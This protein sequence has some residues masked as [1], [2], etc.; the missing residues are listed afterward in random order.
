MTHATALERC[1]ARLPWGHLPREG[2]FAT[3]A[4]AEWLYGEYFI[5]WRAPAQPRLEYSGSPWF[6]AELTA[7]CAGRTTFEPGFTVTRRVAG[8]AFVETAGISLWVPQPRALRPSNARVGTAV[9]VA[10]PCIREAAIAG[11]FTIVSRAGRLDPAAPHLK[12]YV[13]ATPA[14]A[15][16]LLGGLLEAPSLRTARFEAKVTNDPAHFGR[17]DTL[18]LYV[19]PKH[20]G[21]VAAFLRRFAR[22]TPRALNSGTPPMTFPLA[23]GVAIAESPAHHAESFGSHRCRLVAEG[24]LT[25]RAEG[26]PMLTAVAERFEREGLSWDEPWFG[27]LPRGWLARL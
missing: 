21:R 20:A 25:A 22:A 5:S 1:V 15:V 11:F 14:G 26:R 19:T 2:A 8:G 18:L 27:A 12:F 17:T 3:P 9:A 24:L 13:N 23:R 16:A 6:V 4:L 7:R 10:L